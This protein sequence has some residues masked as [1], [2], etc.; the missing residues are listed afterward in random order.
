MAMATN[1]VGHVEPDL[2][3]RVIKRKRM[4]EVLSLEFQKLGLEPCL[5]SRWLPCADLLVC[6]RPWERECRNTR[7]AIRFAGAFLQSVLAELTGTVER[8][9]GH[10]FPCVRQCP[11]AL[12]EESSD[13]GSASDC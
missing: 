11:G 10:G 9:K 7:E 12:S 3:S 13:C 5:Y 4:L 2:D 6:K 8:W 1:V